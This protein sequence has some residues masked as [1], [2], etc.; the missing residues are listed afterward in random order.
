MEVSIAILT[1][2]VCQ[3]TH[4][5]VKLGGQELYVVSPDVQMT[6]VTRERV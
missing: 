6:A 2:N 3:L 1:A 5:N 4:A